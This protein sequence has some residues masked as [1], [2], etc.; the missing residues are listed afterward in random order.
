M[1][2]VDTIALPGVGRPLVAWFWP[3]APPKAGTEA[4]PR[5][6]AQRAKGLR[7]DIGNLLY[8]RQERCR[9]RHLARR[10]LP[11]SS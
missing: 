9:A 8:F 5:M 1:L 7:V 6:M 2:G 11:K 10:L 3:I 4:V